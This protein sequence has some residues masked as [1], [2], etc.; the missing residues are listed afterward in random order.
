MGPAAGVAKFD[1]VADGQMSDLMNDGIFMAGT[2]TGS[3][4]ENLKM[5]QPNTGAGCDLGRL[6]LFEGH[7]ASA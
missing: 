3:G 6:L 1:G 5:C 7:Q 4:A 2:G